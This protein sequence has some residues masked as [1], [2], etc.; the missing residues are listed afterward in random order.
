MRISCNF[1]SGNI[2]VKSIQSARDIRLMIRRDNGSHFYQWFHFRLTG[3]KG[4]NC[5]LRI[6]NA[7]K[8]AYPKG[9]P[10]YRAC[11]SYDREDW[12]RV[13]TR[14][15]GKALIIRHRPLQDSVTYAYFAPYSMERH[16]DLV[17]GT[18]CQPGVELEVLGQTLNGQD[19]DLLKFDA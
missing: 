12:F 17:A 15:D 5:V 19:M 3:A 11:A 2:I 6:T 14:F 1:D 10:G 8:S 9:W 4:K 7:G 18:A 16:A 13:P